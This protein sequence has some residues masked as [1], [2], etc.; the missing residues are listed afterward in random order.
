MTQDFAK[1]K[2]PPAKRKPA[3]SKR[4]APKPKSQV[5]G[6]V[7]LFTGTILGAFIMFLA[8]LSGV[9]PQQ[10]PTPATAAKHE[11]PSHDIPKPR[12]D[13]YQLLKET[14]VV[15]KEVPSHTP[16]EAAAIETQE[17]ILQ[18][19][20]FK[21]NADA[22][23]LRAELILMNLDAQVE[24][25]TVRNGETWHRVLVGP[26]QSRSKV[27]KARSVL[28]SNDINPLLLKRKAG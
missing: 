21:K 2:R 28:V 14:E 18:V 1:K 22:D 7:W 4:A 19:G 26:F 24:T 15:V 11:E 16:K 12:F 6:W 8:Y 3:S 25:V 17:F 20:S 9:T 23:R 27:A 10:T 13:F 5:P